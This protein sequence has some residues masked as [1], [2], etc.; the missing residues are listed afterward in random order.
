M[1]DFPRFIHIKFCLQMQ[2][3]SGPCHIDDDLVKSLFANNYSSKKVSLAETKEKF[4]QCMFMHFLSQ[5]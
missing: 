4:L 5:T 3:G 1:L 2:G